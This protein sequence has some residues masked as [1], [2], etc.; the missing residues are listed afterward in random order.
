LGWPIAAPLHRCAELLGVDVATIQEAAANVEPYIR[1]DGTRIWSLMR[2]Q[3]QL[4]QRRTAG[5]EAATST[6]DEG[7]SRTYS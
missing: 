6:V 5:G 3:R 2:L 1:A 7:C 4:R